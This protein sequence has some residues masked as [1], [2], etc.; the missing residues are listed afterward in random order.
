MLPEI[1]QQKLGVGTQWALQWT[2]S[3]ALGSRMPVIGDQE[4]PLN[5]VHPRNLPR[6]RT[7]SFLRKWTPST[8]RRSIRTPTELGRSLGRPT[9]QLRS[10]KSTTFAGTDVSATLSAGYSRSAASTRPDNSDEAAAE[11]FCAR[12]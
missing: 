4:M 7:I 9:L 12:G 5:R 8:T 10:P 2:F 6:C 3:A 11:D 1:T